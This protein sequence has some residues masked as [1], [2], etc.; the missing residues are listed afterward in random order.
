M[1]VIGRKLDDLPWLII[2]EIYRQSVHQNFIM[3]G[4]PTK[5]AKRKKSYPWPILRK[6][7]TLKNSHYVEIIPGGV[8]VGNR[9]VPYN[10]AQNFGVPPHLIG[11]KYLLGQPADRK[12]AVGVFRSHILG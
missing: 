6:S 3:G 2:G 5:W 11:R 1:R 4:R 8:A 9:L 10:F 7:D 12:K